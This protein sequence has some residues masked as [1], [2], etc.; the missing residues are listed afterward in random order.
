MSARF[1]V[2]V[3]PGAEAGLE[4]RARALASPPEAV[5]A[6]LRPL[7]KF[8]LDGTAYAVD[9]ALLER[10]VTRLGPTGPLAGAPAAI[11]GLAFIDSVPHVAVDLLEHT[12]GAARS[13]EALAAAPA[14]VLRREEGARAVCVE[15]PLELMDAARAPLRPAQDEA[16]GALEVEGRL[17]DGT[18]LLSGPG[19]L[20]WAAAL[21]E[22]R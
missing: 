14:L 21:E 10:V 5:T 19:L 22:G 15:G 11:R 1:E 7:V 9:L 13:L 3:A 6:A 16:A 18:L 20:A 4:A 8:A 12:T 2:R 17:P